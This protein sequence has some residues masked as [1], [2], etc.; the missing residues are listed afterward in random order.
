MFV[1]PILVSINALPAYFQMGQLA[2]HPGI[3]LKEVDAS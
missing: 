3:H 2:L 1:F